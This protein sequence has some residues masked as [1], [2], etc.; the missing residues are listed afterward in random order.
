M[1]DTND[2]QTNAPVD[3]TRPRLQKA[4]SKALL[5]V[6]S[7]MPMQEQA[8][9]QPLTVEEEMLKYRQDIFRLNQT[10]TAKEKSVAPNSRL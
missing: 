3:K 5:R 7:K 10:L 4:L 2:S 6:Q 1:H 9:P 8:P